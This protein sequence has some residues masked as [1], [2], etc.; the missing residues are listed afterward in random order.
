MAPDRL[1]SGV[2]ELPTGLPTGVLPAGVANGERVPIADVGAP[3]RRA[4]VPVGACI[5]GAA[6]GAD[7]APCSTDLS[8]RPAAITAPTLPAIPPSA[9]RRVMSESAPALA[10]SCSSEPFRGDTR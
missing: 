5:V 1:W 7:A 2:S 6:G 4:G 3:T 10:G 9:S 8:G